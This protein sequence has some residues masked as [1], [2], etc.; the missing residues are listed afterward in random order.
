MVTLELFGA[1]DAWEIRRAV[2]VLG[3]LTKAQRQCLSE[4]CERTPLTLVLGGGLNIK[5][6]L[7]A[8]AP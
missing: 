2:Q 6:A 1:P 5:T 3:E 4:L 8:Q 7:A